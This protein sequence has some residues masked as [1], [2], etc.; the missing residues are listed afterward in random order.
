[1]LRAEQST[2]RI[3]LAARDELWRV[4]ATRIGVV[5]NGVPMRHTA[6]GYGYGYGYGESYSYGQVSYAAPE[7]NGRKS[8][9]PALLAKK[10]GEP[11]SSGSEQE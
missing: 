11:V 10:D 2:R 8:K 1:M 4:R 9:R 5:V 6:Y 7:E 3:A